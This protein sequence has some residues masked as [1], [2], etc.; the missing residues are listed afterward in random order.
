MKAQ[1]LKYLQLVQELS[2]ERGLTQRD[3]FLRLGMAQGLVN[4]YLK[5]LAQKGWIKL[6]TAPP[7]RMLYWLT[8]KGMTEKSRLTYE[9][10]AH[11]YKLFREAHRNASNHLNRLAHDGTRRVVFYGAEPAAEVASMSLVENRL[12][13][14]GIVDEDLKGTTFLGQNVLGIDDLDRL[15]FDCILLVKYSRKDD[16]ILRRLLETKRRV[17][18]IF[19]ALPDEP[20]E[21]AP[22]A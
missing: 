19:D 15:D 1:D 14:A 20:S 22:K 21:D 12:K 2:E 5:R 16:A 17:V 7:K 4:R 3:L 18:S 6:T 8:P 10:V 9:F 13:L 11:T